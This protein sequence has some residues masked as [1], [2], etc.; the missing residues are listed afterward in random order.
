M[1]VP[2]VS[3]A[4]VG[5]EDRVHPIDMWLRAQ[6]KDDGPRRTQKGLAAELGV[7]R[8]YLSSILRGRMRPSPE[9]MKAMAKL[10]G[11]AVPLARIVAWHKAYP[12]T[13]TPRRGAKKPALAVVTPIKKKVGS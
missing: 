6:R 7:S 1:S 13:W 2:A 10:T 5:L 8:G 9:L 11:R 4:D 12:P 3:P